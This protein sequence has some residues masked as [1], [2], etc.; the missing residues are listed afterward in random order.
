VPSFA[1]LRSD[2]RF[3]AIFHQHCQYFDESSIRRLVERLNCTL[4]KVAFNEDGSN[5]GSMLFAFKKANGSPSRTWNSTTCSTQPAYKLMDIKT[6][7]DFYIF[8]MDRVAETL[9]NDTSK[10]YGY[11]AAH[12]L[13]T[14]NYHLHGEIGK[15]AGILDDDCLKHQ[16]TFKNIPITIFDPNQILISD[17][18]RF[19]VTSM[20][21][22]RTITRNLLGKYRNRII[23]SFLI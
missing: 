10:I 3:D 12:M 8:S 13:S 21:N 6:E 23:S 18:D 9:R 14:L 19:F 17:K 11:G 7:K 1:H 15:F 4:V 20:E 16:T 2:L 5:G 22:R